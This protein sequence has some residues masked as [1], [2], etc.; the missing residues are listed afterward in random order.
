MGIIGSTLFSQ[1]Q[2]VFRGKVLDKESITPLSGVEIYCSNTNNLVSTGKDGTFEIS[3]EE[4]AA[5]QIILFKESYETN[6]QT[7]NLNDSTIKDIYLSRLSVDLPAVE[8][9]AQKKEWFALKQLQDVEG[10]QINAGKKSEVVV[11][12]LIEG[13]LANNVSRQ[14]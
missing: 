3:Y 12:D 14:I 5:Y 1:A 10:T 11:M 9:A 2:V 13:N 8:I 7:I 4:K 6:Y